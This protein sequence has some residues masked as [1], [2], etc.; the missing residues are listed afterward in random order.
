MD[1]FRSEF[2]QDEANRQ[3]LNK[4]FGTLGWV[5]KMTGQPNYTHGAAV[6]QLFRTG[7]TTPIGSVFTAYRSTAIKVFADRYGTSQ[8]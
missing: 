2:E 6:W 4:A 3:R 1:M 7:D 8:S 5:I